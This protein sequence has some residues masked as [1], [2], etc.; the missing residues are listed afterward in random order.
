MPQSSLTQAVPRSFM[1]NRSY[2]AHV[3]A[4][5]MAPRSP[6]LRHAHPGV[7]TNIGFPKI[8][9]EGHLGLFTKIYTRKNDPL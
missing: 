1:Q 4:H 8:L 2:H 7:T 5:I 3:K 9:S 6:R